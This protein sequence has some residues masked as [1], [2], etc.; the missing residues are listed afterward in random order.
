MSWELE[1]IGYINRRK[2]KNTRSKGRR[3]TATGKK[4]GV[5]LCAQVMRINHID[6]QPQFC[7]KHI[8]KNIQQKAILIWWCKSLY[9]VFMV[10]EK[11]SIASFSLVYLMLHFISISFLSFLISSTFIIF[12]INTGFTFWKLL[13]LIEDVCLYTI[14]W[15]EIVEEHCQSLGH[16]QN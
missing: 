10:S 8:Q 12:T 7:R 5:Q 2:P 11:T 6:A 1:Q 15:V 9:I 13:N 14:L 16:K 3:Q 4:N